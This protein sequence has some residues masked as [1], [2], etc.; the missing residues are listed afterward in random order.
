MMIDSSNSHSPRSI[1]P[2]VSLDYELLDYLIEQNTRAGDRVPALGDLSNELCIS[3][4]KL[5]EQLEVAR[6]LGL[7]TVRPRTGIHRQPFDFM[8]A[9][10][11]SL[12]FA[13]AN[14]LRHFDTYSEL[15]RHVEK[16]FWHEAVASLTDDDKQHLRDLVNLAWEKLKGNPIR[17]PHAEH[18]QFHL[19]IFS[20]IDNTF[21]RGILEAYW[22]AYEAVQ[23]NTY[24][25][26][27]YLNEV[28]SYHEQI[29]DAIIAGDV[30]ASLHAFEEHTRLLPI[31]A[32]D[33]DEE[34][35][36]D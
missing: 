3:V 8:P 6:C 19:A 29:A 31:L 34:Q 32:E 23:L 27:A 28:W 18:R 36:A 22:E 14:D 17:I 15:R 16:A 24:A 4:S 25:D 13:L 11:L 12:F 10:R 33:H 2:S 7:V 9:V 5:R 21:V 1:Q 20:R 35:S 30:E 26:Y